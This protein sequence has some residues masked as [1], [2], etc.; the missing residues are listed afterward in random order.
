MNIPVTYKDIEING[1]KFRLN[2]MDARTGSYMLFKLMKILTPIFKNV[3]E[4]SIKDKS[5]EDLNL[6]ELAESL[7]DLKKEEF[8]FIQD[9]ALKVVDEIYPAGPER[10]FKEEG[11]WGSADIQFDIGLAM[12][13]TIQSLVFNMQD[14][15]AGSPFTSL[16]KGLT[17][18]Q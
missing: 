14:F 17:I 7:F 3:S 5:I 1:R 6:T 10:V 9:S 16:M 4:E 13:L 15:F 2:K 11:N 8:E 12:N 18:S